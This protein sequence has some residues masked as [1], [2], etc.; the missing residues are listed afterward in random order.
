MSSVAEQ[1]T[2]TDPSV[3]AFLGRQ[4]GLFIDGGWVDSAASQRL[5]VFDPS[6]GQV[7]AT[8][9]LAN[10]ADVDRAVRSAHKA[11]EAGV[12]S[13]LPP[14][15][16]ERILLRFA[17][18][19]EGVAEELAQLETLNQGKSINI[20]RYVDVGGAPAY[21]RYVAGLATKITGETF[22][23]SIGAVPGAKYTAYTR[24]EPVGVV[25]AISPWNFPMMIGLW[26]IMPA[27]AAGCTVVLKPSEV[28]PITS[29][30]LAE[31]ARDAGVPAGVFNV[32]TGDG[33][34]GR[35]LVEHPLVS[36]ITFTGS[37]ATGKAIARIAADRLL[38]TSLELGGKNPAIFLK[39]APIEQAV[40]GALLGGFF[41]N[42]QVCAASSRLYVAREIYADF[43]DALSAA[44]NA[45]SIGP[46]MD[47]TAQINPLA[48]MAHRQKVLAHIEGARRDGARVAAGEGLLDGAGYYVRPTVIV[49]A[50]QDL[51]ISREEV[52]GPVVTVLPFTDEEEAIRLAN[53]TPMGLTASLWTN[54]LKKTLDYVPRL[55]AGTVWVNC[56]NLIDPNMPFGG[57]KESGIG[58]DFGLASLDGYTEVKSVC[59]SH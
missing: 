11:F 45:M 51:A 12:W 41:N 17:D 28:T 44:V 59:I 43:V 24:R 40:G 37:T 52:F 38:R 33:A 18:L 5:D 48:S 3:T 8:A 7:I 26:K 30:R 53:D 20:A 14:A 13:G 4:H 15:E 54:D 27:L 47:P 58:R 36:K 19:V 22:D 49:D 56:H 31:L 21:I 32:V 6:S 29:L 39:D 10:A 34:A 23:V 35:A 1:L 25:G 2:Q 57:F 50:G 55:K 16:R 42:G 9:P 46:G